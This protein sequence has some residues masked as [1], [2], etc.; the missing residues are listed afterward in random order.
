MK[1]NKTI[2]I[3]GG[4]GHEASANIYLKMIHYC[5]KKYHAQNDFDFPGVLMEAK[6]CPGFDETGVRDSKMAKDYIVSVAKKLEKN[7]A[8]CIIIPCN[9]IHTFAQEIQENINI[10]FLNI[11]KE[12]KNAVQQ[13]SFQKMGLLCSESTNRDQLYQKCFVDSGIE[14]VSPIKKQQEILTEVIFSVMG[15]NYGNYEVILLK[16]II[17]EMK[18]AG[19]E[20]II[21]GC[22]ELPLAISQIHTD[23]KLFDTIEILIRSAVDFLFRK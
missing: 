12:T 9:S 22:T 13:Y 3:I 1:T 5:Q 7:G 10:P 11:I 6:S 18:W 14:I 23:E 8:D 21:L 20:S 19:A 4:I 15:G 17:Q 2:G 16:N